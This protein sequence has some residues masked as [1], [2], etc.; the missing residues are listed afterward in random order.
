MRNKIQFALNSGCICMLLT[1][2]VALGAKVLVLGQN[3]IPDPRQRRSFL[4]P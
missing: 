3:F 4:A 2:D 1:E